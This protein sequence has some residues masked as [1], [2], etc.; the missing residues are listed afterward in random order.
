MRT[1][2][3]C[4]NCGIELTNHNWHPLS[5]IVNDQTCKECCIKLSNERKENK[6]KPEFLNSGVWKPHVI[7]TPYCSKFNT[8]CK[9][10]N[11]EKYGRK[12]FICGKPESENITST[13]KVQRLSVHHVNLNK[14]QGCNNHQWSLIPVC[15][16]HHA[17]LHNDLW[18]SRMVYLLKQ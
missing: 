14:D 6:Q 2:K 17:M 11:R 3:P 8:K 7:K 4:M 15:L 1:I 12:C 13:G 5:K 18:E 9:E 16:E 10:S